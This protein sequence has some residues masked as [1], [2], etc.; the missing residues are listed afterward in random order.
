MVAALLLGGVFA[1]QAEDGVSKTAVVLGQ[2]VA[3][4][5]PAATLGLPFSQGARLYF[6]RVNAAG[7][8][9]GRKIEL[10]TL[11]DAGSP[12]ATVANTQKL[13]A[14]G[15]LSLFG[16]YGSPQVTAAYPAIK[17]G[18]ALLFAPMAAADE[19]RGALYPNLYSLRPGYSEEAA[20]ITRH[21]E[22]LGARKL[23]ILHAK[24]GESLA[25]LDSAE[26]TMTSLGAN[27]LV[28]A[29]IEAVDKALAA[30]PES[31]LVIS[32]PRG[33]AV[34]IRELRAKGFRGPIYGFSNTGESLLAEQL[35]A[36]GA[37]VVVVRVV[38]R[39][40]GARLA[41]VRELQADA[42]AANLGKP[43]VYMLEGYIAARVYAEALRRI[44]KEPTRAR[45]R[46]ALD[47]LDNVSV[48]GFRVHFAE[49]RVASKLVELSLI[50][51]QGRV[52]E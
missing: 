11:D 21:A 24:D 31:V 48:G 4:S 43:N 37:G 32:D 26:R 23:A 3:L 14:Q 42:A 2:S 47:G 13:L 34:A 51:S 1:A 8:I 33:A 10:V 38:P 20:A 9:N 30:R 36:A 40:E 17:D 41:V 28:K 39:S 35:G 25:A 52:R 27:L 50:D 16:Y 6:D 18:D 22:T 19:F 46:G 29:P 45:L 12:A 49:E 15:V 44:A 7:G 5:G